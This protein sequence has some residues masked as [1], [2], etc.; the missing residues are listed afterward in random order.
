MSDAVEAAR[1]FI[2]C[3]YGTRTSRWD[4]ASVAAAVQADY[5]AYRDRMLRTWPLDRSDDDLFTAISAY[6]ARI[7]Y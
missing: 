3:L 5:E 7:G 2:R 6:G 4:D 1:D